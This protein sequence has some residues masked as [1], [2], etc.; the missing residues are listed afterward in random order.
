[1][2]DVKLIT[3]EL[4]SLLFIHGKCFYVQFSFDIMKYISFL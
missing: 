2:M 4:F 3:V 1:M